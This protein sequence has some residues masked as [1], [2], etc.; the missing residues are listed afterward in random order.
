MV[1]RYGKERLDETVELMLEVVLSK[2]P[3]S[4]SPGMIFP[5]RW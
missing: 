1:S 4:V 5:G 3:L 2:R